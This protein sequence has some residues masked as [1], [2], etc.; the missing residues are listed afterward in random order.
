MIPVN[1]FIYEHDYNN[2]N[3]VVHE[4]TTHCYIISYQLAKFLINLFEILQNHEEVDKCITKYLKIL[5]I[6]VHSTYPLVAWSPM[7]GDSDIR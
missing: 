7:S 6:P 2:W 1:D 5:K 3:N 4:R